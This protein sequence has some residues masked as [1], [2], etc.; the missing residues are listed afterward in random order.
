MKMA[1][2]W[3]KNNADRCQMVHNT[4]RGN[5][6]ENLYCAYPSFTNGRVAVE[7]WYN[8]IKHN[9]FN[10]PGFT[11]GTGNKDIAYL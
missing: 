4:G 5:I 11:S 1:Q 2:N 7:D 9:N 10:R 3:V 6:G 8:E